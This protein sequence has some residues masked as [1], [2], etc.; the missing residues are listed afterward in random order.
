MKKDMTFESA[1]AELEDMVRKL[2]GGDMT[3]D[4]QIKAFSRSVE[5]VKFCNSALDNAEQKV[6]LLTEGAD[7]TVTD[8]AFTVASDEA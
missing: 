7:G 2:E 1:L 4:E 3:L 8:T 6:R 5:L